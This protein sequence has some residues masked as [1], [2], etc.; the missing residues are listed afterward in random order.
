MDLESQEGK[1]IRDRAREIKA[2]CHRAIG[3]GG[4]FDVN[5]DAFLRG[6]PIR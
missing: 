3:T 4:S 5:L 6:V 1:Q 2:M